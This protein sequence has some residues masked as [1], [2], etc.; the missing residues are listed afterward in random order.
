MADNLQVA[1]RVRP[2][3]DREIAMNSECCISMY[4]IKTINIIYIGRIYIRNATRY[5]TNGHY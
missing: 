3:N 2:F 1:V 5:T 4:N